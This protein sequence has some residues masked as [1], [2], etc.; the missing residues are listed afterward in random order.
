MLACV[1][2]SRGRQ[3]CASQAEEGESSR[4]GSQIA[5]TARG[6]HEHTWASLSAMV[7]DG[8]EELFDRSI[9]NE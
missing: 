2:K 8:S 3:N 5:K 4:R 9:E 7:T 6:N 1:Q